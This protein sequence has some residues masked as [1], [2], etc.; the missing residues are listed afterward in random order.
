MSNAVGIVL[1]VSKEELLGHEVA[2]AAKK[3][4]T[5]GKPK[6]QN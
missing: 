1:K 5:S 6:L 4:A 2:R 3:I